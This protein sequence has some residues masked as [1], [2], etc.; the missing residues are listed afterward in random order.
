MKHVLGLSLI[1][2]LMLIIVIAVALY[3]GHLM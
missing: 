1:A 3:A 2:A